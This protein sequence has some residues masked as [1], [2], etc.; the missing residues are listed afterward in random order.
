VTYNMFD[1]NAWA[2]AGLHVM[3]RSR[4][5]AGLPAGAVFTRRFDGG[6]ASSIYWALLP[7]SPDSGLAPPA[8]ADMLLVAMDWINSN[9]MYFWTARVTAD[10]ASTFT[11]YWSPTATSVPVTAFTQPCASCVPQPGTNKQLD[12]LGDR[13]MDPLYYRNMGTYEAYVVAHSVRP[14]TSTYTGIRW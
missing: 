3:Q 11:V 8:G 14:T 9:K 13:L 10:T 4:M 2:G 7:S 12:T 6:S 5:L 1:P